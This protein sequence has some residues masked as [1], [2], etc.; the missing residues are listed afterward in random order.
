VRRPDVSLTVEAGMVG[1]VTAGPPA[2]LAAADVDAVL[3]AVG[4]YV[5]AATIEPLEHGTTDGLEP[6]LAATAAPA[7]AGPERDA[8]ADFG[9]PEVTKLS[10]TLAPVGLRGLVDRA[11]GI[12]LVGATVDVTARATAA[13]GRLEIHRTGELMYQRDG[14]DWKLLGFRLAVARDGAGLGTAPTTSTA[15]VP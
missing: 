3:G 6:L 9:A 7:L 10:V 2:E 8:L 1:T 14:A 13:D 5:E 12:D 11:G 4:D 15:S